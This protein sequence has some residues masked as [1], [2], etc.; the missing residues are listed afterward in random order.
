VHSAYG[1]WGDKVVNG[2]TVQAV[3]RS[4]FVVGPQGV[5]ESAH[6]G[7][8]VEGHVPGLVAELAS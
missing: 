1:A 4:T 6:Y 8:N 5:V 2:E 7:V 3:V